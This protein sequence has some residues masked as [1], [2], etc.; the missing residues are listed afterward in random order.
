MAKSKQSEPVADTAPSSAGVTRYP[1]LQHAM[2]GTP[3]ESRTREELE[4]IARDGNVA[5]KGTGKDG[6]VTVED[7]AG[8]IRAATTVTVTRR[9]DALQPPEGSAPAD[10]R[11]EE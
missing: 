4:S 2:T 9:P 5:V 1:S 10:T 3:L 6:Y 8:A 7:L 11:T